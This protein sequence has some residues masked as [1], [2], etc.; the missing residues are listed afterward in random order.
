MTEE[1]FK[2][3][4]NRLWK[5]EE[6]AE[7]GWLKALRSNNRPEIARNRE[8]YCKIPQEILRLPEQHS[9]I[10]VDLIAELFTERRKQR[11]QQWGIQVTRA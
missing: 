3:E 5:D 6:D 8:H 7:K 2:K 10:S 11:L 4:L 9:E 1:E